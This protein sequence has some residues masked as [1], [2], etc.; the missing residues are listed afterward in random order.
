MARLTAATGWLTFAVLAVLGGWLMLGA[1][2]VR[3]LPLFGY[4]YCPAPRAPKSI[5]L[6]AAAEREHVLKSRVHRFEMQLA[7]LDA[8]QPPPPPPAPE[9]APLPPAAAPEP[10]PQPQQMKIPATLAE[11]KG[12]W[13][14]ERGDKQ[15]SSDDER[16]VPMGKV[17]TCYCF[18]E[19]GKGRIVLVYTDGPVCRGRI[20]ATLTPM[21]LKIDQPGFDCGVQQGTLRGHVKTFVTCRAGENDVALCD[22]Q[23]LGRMRGLSR[24]EKYQRT[25]NDQC[26]LE[27]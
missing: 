20:S 25:T 19:T 2:E 1:C 10:P 9:P 17:R 15:L 23:S 5:D 7:A 8:C 3:P 4:A 12:C 11:L 26:G 13:V 16:R 27:N 22:T 18:G 21:K 24:D 14:S 6:M